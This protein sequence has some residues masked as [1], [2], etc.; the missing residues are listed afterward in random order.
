MRLERAELNRAVWKAIVIKP[1]G[2]TDA[3][4]GRLADELWKQRTNRK[5]DE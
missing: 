5:E 2:R 4:D 3:A 1:T